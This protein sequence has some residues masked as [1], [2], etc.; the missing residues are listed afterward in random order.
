V[1]SLFNNAMY[2]CFLSVLSLK[3]NY[4]RIDGTTMIL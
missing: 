4:E 2:S 3:F 1:P